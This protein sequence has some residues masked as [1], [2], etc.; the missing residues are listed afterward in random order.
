M[1]DLPRL[2]QHAHVC[3][4]KGTSLRSLFE[5]CAGASGHHDSINPLPLILERPPPLV[6]NAPIMWY[7][8]TYWEYLIVGVWAGLIL[9]RG[10]YNLRELELARTAEVQILGKIRP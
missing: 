6:L 2:T 3:L 4:P 9:G 10:D 5:G 8:I 7:I 1:Q